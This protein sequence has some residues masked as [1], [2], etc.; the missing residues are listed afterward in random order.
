[1][2]IDPYLSLSTKLNSECIKYINISPPD[3]LNLIEE[4]VRN[5][6]NSLEQGENFLYR[7]PLAQKPRTIYKKWDLMKLKS[8]AQKRAVSHGQRFLTNYTF[9]IGLISKIHKEF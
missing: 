2:K 5:I 6:L 4:K 3:T 8:H 1:M 9:D 7:R